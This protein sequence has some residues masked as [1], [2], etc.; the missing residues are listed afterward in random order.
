MRVL[1]W[2]VKRNPTAFALASSS[3]A[4]MN[5][6]LLVLAESP[7]LEPNSCP[8]AERIVT[9]KGIARA[10][11]AD[12][13]VE[14]LR[15]VESSLRVAEVTQSDDARMRALLV[16][17]ADGTQPVL[18]F[19]A[20]LPSRNNQVNDR[21]QDH[22]V[23]G[24]VDWIRKVER[25]HACEAIVIG[26]LNLDPYTPAMV[27]LRGFN[28]MMSPRRQSRAFRRV[29]RPT[30]F[31]PTWRLFGREPYGT[32]HLDAPGALGYHWHLLDQVLMRCELA[33]HLMNLDIICQIGD[34]ALT[35]P[36]AR[37]P[38]TRYSD[39]FPLFLEMNDALFLPPE[40]HHGDQASSQ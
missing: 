22:D 37:Q 1:F 18:L 39:H 27:S 14:V 32:Y 40:V 20:H 17:H 2:N 26:D 11:A 28:A 38:S 10:N 21:D 6:D 34:T 24:Y 23:E 12:T 36:T 5:L 7:T 13:C 30:F 19:V 16:K 33:P 29:R 4:L 8:A 31:N 15:N 35:S 25:K 9:P 3:F